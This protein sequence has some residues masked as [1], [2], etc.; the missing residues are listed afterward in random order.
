MIESKVVEKRAHERRWN[1]FSSIAVL[2]LLAIALALVGLR[3]FGLQPY[4]IM[5][6]SMEPNYPVGALVYVQPVDPSALKQGDVITFMNDEKTTV[7]H[8]INEIITETSESGE[9]TLRFRTKGDANNT[10]DGKLVH[11]KN[12]IGTPI[13]AIPFLG[14]LS[15]YIQS[16][17]GLYLAIIIGTFLVSMIIIPSAMD[18]KERRKT[19]KTQP[20]NC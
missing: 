7:T 9:E 18:Y 19:Q 3:L 13:V 2:I 10:T 11:Y 20:T 14:Y 12:V 4:T 16:P 15:Y 8:R 5:S 6:G 17:P 1:V